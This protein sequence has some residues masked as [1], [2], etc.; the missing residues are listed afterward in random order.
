MCIIFDVLRIARKIYGN[1]PGILKDERR[2]N[3]MEKKEPSVDLVKEAERIVHE[4]ANRTRTQY[5]RPPVKIKHV[6]QTQAKQVK[7]I[8]RNFIQDIVLA[9]GCVTLAAVLMWLAL[10]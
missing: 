2:A 10:F 3:K 6:Q 5:M 4:Y 7:K 8:K 9:L 1:N